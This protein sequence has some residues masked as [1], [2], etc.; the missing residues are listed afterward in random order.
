MRTHV[1]MVCICRESSTFSTCG[2]H[3]LSFWL[4]LRLLV[5]VV[6]CVAAAVVVVVAAVLSHQSFCLL[7]PLPL[8]PS[9]P[10]PLYPS[11][12]CFSSYSSSSSDISTCWFSI[13]SD[14]M[15]VD[16]D[17]SYLQIINMLSPCFFE[18]ELVLQTQRR[19]GKRPRHVPAAVLLADYGTHITLIRRVCT[20]TFLPGSTTIA[21]TLK[22]KWCSTGPTTTG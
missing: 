21:K 2:L 7:L 19:D 11:S 16:Q 3:V 4:W 10:L 15:Q 8:Y 5:A 9:R 12:C 13:L 22:L 6:A 14:I 20:R 1:C 17:A 18:V